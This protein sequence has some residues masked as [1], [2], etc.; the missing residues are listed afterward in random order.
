MLSVPTL[1][2]VAEEVEGRLGDHQ[3]EKP[4]SDEVHSSLVSSNQG[5]LTVGEGSVQLT[6]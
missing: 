1:N 2:V 6:S 4:T 3:G 5:I